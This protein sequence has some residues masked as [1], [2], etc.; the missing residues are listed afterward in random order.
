MNDA[1]YN[2]HKGNADSFLKDPTVRR[3]YARRKG[4]AKEL[5][6]YS[7]WSKG[8]LKDASDEKKYVTKEMI[9][10]AGQIQSAI[11][12][13]SDDIVSGKQDLGPLFAKAQVYQNIVP[14]VDVMIKQTLTDSAL[15]RAPINLRTGEAITD[16][17]KFQADA[18]A[19]V[20]K[21]KTGDMDRDDFITG[22]KKFFTGDYE[23]AIRALVESGK[24][25]EEQYDA[26]LNYFAGQ[27]QEQFMLD[28]K[29]LSNESRERAQDAERNRQWAAK[30]QLEKEQG[31]GYWDVVNESMNFVDEKSGKP[32]TQ[33]IEGWKNQKL[34]ASQIQNKMLETAR[35]N[36]IRN[37]YI[38]PYTK[39]VTISMR[40]SD[41]EAD[42]FQSVNTP[43]AKLFIKE[44]TWSNKSKK[45]VYNQKPITYNEFLNIK[46]FKTKDGK[47]KYLFPNDQ[48]ITSDIIRE[49]R[50]ASRGN[51]IFL[52]ANEIQASYGLMNDK[53]ENIETLN[54]SNIDQFKP[55]KAVNLKRT[56]GVPYAQIPLY[57]E[58]G[59]QKI[60]P[61]TN[62]PMYEYKALPGTM[63]FNNQISTD[64]G[65]KPL[66]AIHGDK[67]KANGFGLEYETVGEGS[68]SGGS[69]SDEE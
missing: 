37:A 55:N 35:N 51:K 64:A 47:A 69:S 57:D 52:R 40:P 58:K 44:R 34:S 29:L 8:L 62:K 25:S 54:P 42:A 18:S 3:E 11:A 2:K 63:F 22:Y 43:E 28:H 33:L 27:M 14:Q 46:D 65:R 5:T 68:Y 30:F 67:Y 1:L 24:Y 66:N 17:A 19:F 7:E 21:A 39:A 49:Y 20:Q 41:K 48:K 13:N 6:H 26:A 61:E 45:W 32:I 23:R 9:D 16:P 31:K 15:G 36:G 38:N 60:D 4:L 50:D 56:V 12:N 59:D 10:I 53:T